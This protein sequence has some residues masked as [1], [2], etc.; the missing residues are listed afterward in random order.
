M[1]AHYD[2]DSDGKLSLREL[3][4]CLADLSMLDESE[5]LLFIQ[6][7]VSPE[8]PSAPLLYSWNTLFTFANFINVYKLFELC[9]SRSKEKTANILL[10]QQDR[11]AN[12]RISRT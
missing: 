12:V 10:Q 11:F 7:L 2:E 6:L 5:H 9:Y 1:F 4:Q 8:D 3:K